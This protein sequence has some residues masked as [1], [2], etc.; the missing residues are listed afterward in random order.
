MFVLIMFYYSFDCRLLKQR[1]CAFAKLYYLFHESLAS[2]KHFLC[3]VLQTPIL[4]LI[5]DTD[6]YLDIDPEKTYM[7]LVSELL[8]IS[9]TFLKFVVTFRFS[10]NDQKER[11]SNGHAEGDINHESVQYRKWVAGKLVEWTNNIIASLQENIDCFPSSLAWLVGKIANM[12]GDVYG[13]NSK[14]V[15]CGLDKIFLTLL[16]TNSCVCLYIFQSQ[17]SLTGDSERFSVF[18]PIVSL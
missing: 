5:A 7:R 11:L 9:A 6:S 14:E 1:S 17:L 10:V 3:A 15:C 4:Q 8:K 2:S 16:K 13:E 12:L 18:T